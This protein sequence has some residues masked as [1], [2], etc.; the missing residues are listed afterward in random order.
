MPEWRIR[1]FEL[2][3]QA[4]TDAS[5]TFLMERKRVNLTMKGTRKHWETM[6]LSNTQGVDNFRKQLTMRPHNITIVIIA[7]MRGRVWNSLWKECQDATRINSIHT[8]T[9]IKHSGPT[10]IGLWKAFSEMTVKN[11]SSN[12]SSRLRQKNHT[13]VDCRI[14]TWIKNHNNDREG[15]KVDNNWYT[16]RW[17]KP[18]NNKTQSLLH[19]CYHYFTENH[20]KKPSWPSK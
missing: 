9:S 4:L 10:K 15:K 12:N 13:T 18:F 20:H 5:K 8:Q 1:Q 2:N 6:S 7:E 11:E 3:L 16:K 14:A 19:H 17:F